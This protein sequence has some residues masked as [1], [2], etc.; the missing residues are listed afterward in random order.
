[1]KILF[2]AAALLLSSTSFAASETF[3]SEPSHTFVQFSYS[4]FGFST[5]TMRFNSSEAKLTLDR[6]AKTGS[7]EMTVDMK[8]VD[9]GSKLDEHI[10]DEDFFNTAKFPTASFKST[11][12]TFEGDKPAS[13]EG[14]LTIKGITK[15]V[16]FKVTSFHCMPHPFAKKDA[17]GANAS[18]VVKRSEFD[19]AKYTPHVSDDVTISVAIEAIK[20]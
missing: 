4:H 8:S 20:Q 15:P 3:V 13:I 6:A 2:T 5:Q 9:T 17:C 1:M 14:N 16:T 12:V 7:A 19:M 11:K 10:Q 18:A